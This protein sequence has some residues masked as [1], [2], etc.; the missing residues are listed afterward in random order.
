V[1]ECEL[2]HV[3]LCGAHL[4]WQELDVDLEIDSFVHPE[5]YPYIGFTKEQLKRVREAIKHHKVSEWVL[6]QIGRY[7]E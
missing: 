1:T 4:H 7:G 3:T 2:K 6:R 5:R